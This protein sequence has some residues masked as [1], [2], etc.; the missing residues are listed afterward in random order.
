[1]KHSDEIVVKN[2]PSTLT[3]LYNT[4]E[5]P[6]QGT[7]II[8]ISYKYWFTDSLALFIGWMALPF[9]LASATMYYLM[10]YCLRRIMM[11][12]ADMVEEVEIVPSNQT[13]PTEQ[14]IADSGQVPDT[15]SQMIK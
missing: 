15:G 1:V 10:A 4:V 11:R 7:T 2:F 13:I 14:K 12:Q 6:Y 8:E 9:I 5:I 3:I